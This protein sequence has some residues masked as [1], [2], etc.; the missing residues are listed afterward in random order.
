M[1]DTLSEESIFRIVYEL[2]VSVDHSVAALEI[3]KIAN[4]ESWCG[5]LDS[6]ENVLCIVLEGTPLVIGEVITCLHLKLPC[7]IEMQELKIINKKKIVAFSYDYFHNKLLQASDRTETILENNIASYCEKIAVGEVIVLPDESKIGEIS[8]ICNLSLKTF[9]VISKLYKELPDFYI[10]INDLQKVF[11]Y[12]SFSSDVVKSLV[13]DGIAYDLH[14][15]DS[16]MNDSLWNLFFSSNK[17]NVILAS[18]EPLYSIVNYIQDSKDLKENV[19]I[20]F[21]P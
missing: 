3:E 17:I 18:S 8:V 10:I 19:L 14:L 16:H 7:H 13:S 9:E 11:D 5:W 2:T 12:C 1:T 4:A 6:K 15:I 21:V 20:G